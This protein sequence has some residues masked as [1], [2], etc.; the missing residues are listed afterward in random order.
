MEALGSLVELCV[1]NLVSDIF[2]AGLTEDLIT[3]LH[4]IACHLP[5]DQVKRICQGELFLGF[6]GYL[7]FWVLKISTTNCFG[8]V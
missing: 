8:G 3:S 7:C 1:A 2:G 4:V 5:S 6:Q